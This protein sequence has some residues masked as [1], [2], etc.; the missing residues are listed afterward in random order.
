M[1]YDFLGASPDGINVNPSSSRYGRLLEIKN[2]KSR[3]IDGTVSKPYWIQTQVQMEVCDLNE[4][5]FLETKFIE[6]E[7]YN[8]YLND[9]VELEYSDDSDSDELNT[10]TCNY[11]GVILYFHKQTESPCYVYKPLNITRL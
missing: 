1:L 8:S 4:C 10:V 9:I 11:K 2:V 6:Y 3:E 7:N 5:D